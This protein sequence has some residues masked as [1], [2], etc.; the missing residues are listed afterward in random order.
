MSGPVPSAERI[1]FDV[2]VFPP[3]GERREACLRFATAFRC[4]RQSAGMPGP[5]TIQAVPAAEF[6]FPVD[7][8][9]KFVD[10]EITN[11]QPLDQSVVL[12]NVVRIALNLQLVE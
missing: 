12:V 2:M 4:G 5:V 9:R 3:C 11:Q 1:L 10:A 8:L 7:S 6:V